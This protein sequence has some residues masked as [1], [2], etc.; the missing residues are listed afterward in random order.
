MP[1]TKLTAADPFKANMNFL[2]IKKYKNLFKNASKLQ[3]KKGLAFSKEMPDI[4]V[5]KTNELDIV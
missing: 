2:K 1:Q 5:E 3:L 4:Y